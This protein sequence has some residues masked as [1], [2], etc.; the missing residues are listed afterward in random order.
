MNG[1]EVRRERERER[2]REK[3]NRRHI[4]LGEESD[5]RRERRLK[6]GRKEGRRNP[7][8]VFDFPHSFFI[9]SSSPKN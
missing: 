6:E 2:E 7:E 4:S 5:I 1:C 3:G 8:D 9:L